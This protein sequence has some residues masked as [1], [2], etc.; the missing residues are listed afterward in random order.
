[1]TLAQVRRFAFSLPEVTEEPHFEYT[2]F[3]VRG[4][5]LATA[6]PGGKYLHVFVRDQERDLA[7]TTEPGFLE[8]LLW[9]G[10]VRGVRVVLATAKPRVVRELVREAWSHKAPKSLVA[11]S[12]TSGRPGAR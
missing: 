12:R 5:I 10:K 9:G 11:K 3:R 4:K 8:P 1:M 7:L 6:P 2:S